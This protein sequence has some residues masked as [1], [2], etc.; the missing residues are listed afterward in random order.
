MAN[1]SRTLLLS[2]WRTGGQSS[3]DLVREFV[4]ELP[5]T[6][7]SEAW[8]RAVLLAMDSRLNFDAEPRVKHT[9]AEEAP[10]ASHPFFWAGYMLVDSGTMPEKV[11]PPPGGPVIKMKKPDKPAEQEEPKEEVKEKPKRKPKDKVG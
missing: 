1:G 8:Q 4:Q 10:K 11:E 6:S 5:H 2:R 9:A 7:P 3:F